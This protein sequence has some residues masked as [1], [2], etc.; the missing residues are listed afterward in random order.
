MTWWLNDLINDWINEWMNEWIQ[1]LCTYCNVFLFNRV[2]LQLIAP[3]KLWPSSY[4]QCRQ[5]FFARYPNTFWTYCMW[6]KMLLWISFESK[7]TCPLDQLQTW[8]GGNFWLSDSRS[9]CAG[10]MSFYML[11]T[12]LFLLF[13]KDHSWLLDGRVVER[14]KIFFQ[15]ACS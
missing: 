15:L 9:K 10:N 5:P 7:N 4:L 2:K 11:S 6:T 13:Q 1:H 12:C 8:F 14:G 3:I